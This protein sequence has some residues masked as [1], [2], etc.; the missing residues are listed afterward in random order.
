LAITTETLLLRSFSD[1][2]M[3]VPSTP[4]IRFRITI[5]HS[6]AAVIRSPFGGG[7]S[8]IGPSLR[9]AAFVAFAFLAFSLALA[10]FLA[11]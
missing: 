6:L 1:L 4:S 9:I 8:G 11:K 7:R 2:G 5:S 3:N 10:F